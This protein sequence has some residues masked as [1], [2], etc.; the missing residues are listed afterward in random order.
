[1]SLP[2]DQESLTAED[3]IAELQKIQRVILDTLM[4]TNFEIRTPMTPII[5][6]S[7][8]LLEEQVGPLNEKQKEF[9]AYIH[10]LGR[11]VLND[12]GDFFAHCYILL[13]NN[14]DLDIAECDLNKIIQSSID[15]A[16]T[17]WQL[18]EIGDATAVQIE[19]DVCPE[20]R[21]IWADEHRVHQALTWLLLE[22]MYE[23]YDE[24]T[25]KIKLT[26]SSQDDQVDFTI[27]GT[28]KR[29]PWSNHSDD[30]GFLGSQKI[31]ETHGGHIYA[32]RQEANG[33][34]I[35]INFSLPID[36]NKPASI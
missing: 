20:I 28:S 22:V 30:P 17:A 23:S 16:V 3:R 4:Y 6:Y 26:T 35:T 21:T 29:S 27:I 14:F 10:K 24:E 31:I 34:K 25:G 32:N 36:L 33:Y 2:D 7:E 1:M 5:G 9:L 8:L 15:A 13:D 18:R 12:W 11:R 19:Q